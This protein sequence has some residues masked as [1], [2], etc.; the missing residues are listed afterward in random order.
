[1]NSVRVAIHYLA[2][3]EAAVAGLLFEALELA[4]KVQGVFLCLRRPNVCVSVS[5]SL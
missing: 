3:T 2:L 1:M 5:L 4:G